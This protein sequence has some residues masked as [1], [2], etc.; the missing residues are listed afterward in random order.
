MKIFLC[1][2][3]L[4]FITNIVYSHSGVSDRYGCHYNR[5]INYYHC[6]RYTT[7]EYN[8]KIKKGDNLQLEAIIITTVAIMLIV[9]FF[10]TYRI[11][12]EKKIIPEVSLSEDDFLIKLSYNF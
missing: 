2:I 3:I 5:T 1:L 10:T 6:H 7:P 4:L 12:K 9:T 8:L 11:E